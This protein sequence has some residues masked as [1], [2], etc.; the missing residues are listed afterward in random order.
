MNPPI[1]SVP[2]VG[3][4]DWLQWRRNGIGASEIGAACG[5]SKYKT[6][7]QL[8]LDKTGR[9]EPTPD[10]PAMRW[11][12]RHER[13][14][15]E[16][17]TSEECYEVEEY[18]AIARR[19]NEIGDYPPIYATPDAVVS[20]PEGV[21]ELL[22]CKTT[23]W[24][25]NQLG[26]QGTDEIPHEWIL[27][28]QTQLVCTGLHVC[29]FAVL[30]DGREMRKYR[31]ERN[32]GL[33]SGIAHQCREFWRH[34]RSDLQ[35]PLDWNNAGDIETFIRQWRPYEGK[36]LDLSDSFTNA[37]EYWTEYELLGGQI[38]ALQKQRDESKA[39]FEASIGNASRV[40][41]PGG[42]EVC[43]KLVKSKGYFVQPREYVR[44]SAKKAKVPE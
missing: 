7:Y 33:L 41:L 10:N 20:S 32:D 12:R 37:I 38:S 8:W 6:R 11:G 30:I 29:H 9:S 36:A 15:V 18:P 14:L 28:A 26:E 25:N 21:I 44:L 3:S 24:R 27:Q 2:E 19:W 22:E 5:V 4:P 39:R 31:V 16:D 13:G 43:A 35:P 17:W 42:V 40:I 1:E 23:T 34:V